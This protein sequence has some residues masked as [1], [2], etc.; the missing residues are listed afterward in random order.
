MPFRRWAAST[1][2]RGGAQAGL[3]W[4]V[5]VAERD[6]ARAERAAR[7]EERAQSS[8]QSDPS[9]DLRPEI[10]A[11]RAIAVS[12]VVVYHLWPKALPGGFTGVDVFFAISGFL[13]TSHLLREVD[14]TGR[15]SLAEFWARR[16]RRIL[17]AAL[18]VIAL[19]AVA[20]IIWVPE[21]YWSQYFGEIRA[22]TAYVQNWHLADAAVDYLA[23]ENNPSPL[24]H[25]WSLSAEEQFY[26]VWPVLILGA[27]LVAAGRFVR[28]RRG[29]ITL[30]LGVVA[31]LSL[32]YAI[33]YTV[34]NPARAFF[35]TPT[36][37]WEF[38]AGG[39]LAILALTRL[40]T[41][42]RIAVSWGGLA[43]L[44]VAALAYSGATP[45]PGYA[46]LLPVL[47]TLAVIWAGAPRGRLSPTAAMSLPPVQFLGGISY[48]VYLWHW[49][50]LIL[51][52]I[53]TGD[54][55]NPTMKI[56]I[57]VA[58]VVLAWLTKVLVEDPVRTGSFLTKRKA[59]WTFA[60]VAVGTA[61]VFVLAAIGS[62]TLDA[63]ERQAE[64]RA[65]RVLADTPRCFGA[66]SHDPAHRCVNPDL[67]RSV[68]PLPVVAATRANSPC[69][70]QKREGLVWP[71]AFGVAESSHPKQ[72][73]A[74]I[75]DSH[76]SHWRAAIDVVA[77]AKKWHGVS[78]ARAGC[79]F[80]RATKKLPEPARS[81]CVDWNRQVVAWLKRHPE[82]TTV[83][84]AQ[85]NGDVGVV[86]H[87]KDVFSTQVAGYAGAWELLPANVKRLYV[88][89][90]T[91]R[92]G[93]DTM[94]CVQQAIDSHHRAGSSCAVPQS[95]ALRRDP[96]EVATRR[97]AKRV[98][99]IDMIRYL[100]DGREC[101]PVI[102][103]ALVYKDNH[104]LTEVY[105]TTL[106]PYLRRE[107]DKLERS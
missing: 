55:I 70:R 68:V 94:A 6:A 82:I 98:K 3:T 97:A 38:A 45:W 85:I 62:S 60:S 4:S 7:R 32:A 64:Q 95:Q 79:P 104:H 30:V 48:S 101:P 24:Q 92:M 19:T 76:A 39:L 106:G 9:R 99:L 90:D 34:S 100:C 23:A 66:A 89:R 16:A 81:Q 63:H 5:T 67:S 87:G 61:T 91:P 20:T 40:P 107:I 42:V 86:T 26:I 77:R 35:V 56:I 11:L 31:A 33:S 18:L 54:A 78:I 72:E 29:A 37:A 10:Q 46:A 88:F 74:V 47:G 52:P 12:L 84:V 15:V 102:G 13:I 69:T 27:A 2:S 57:L 53:I 96:A 103:G 25:F 41:P 50:L 58:T 73:I 21:N 36:R 105:A 43:A 51:L 71:C 14:R 49:P 93:K 65:K 17:P 75:G 22:S 44:L 83:F 28:A 1:A 80:T 8:R 59:R